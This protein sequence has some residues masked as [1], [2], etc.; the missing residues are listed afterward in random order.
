MNKPGSASNFKP[1]TPRRRRPQLGQRIFAVVAILAIL[2]GLYLIGNALIGPGKPISNLFATDTPTPTL[3]YTPTN[4]S[5]PTATPTE[6]PTPTVTFTPTPGAPFQYTVQE[7]EYLATIVD[8]FALGPE[9]I[10]LIQLLNPYDGTP[11]LG[12]DP[13]NNIVYPGQIIWIP[14]PGMALPTATPIPPDL[15]RGTRISYT[16]KA[17]D[18]LGGIAAK[19]NSTEQAIIDE[20]K[21]T[22]PNAL[23]VGQPLVIPVNMV[24]PTATRLPTSTPITPTATF[25]AVPTTKT[26]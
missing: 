1:L 23:F 21:L 5:L 20:N 26:P 14:N 2:G 16:V 10:E 12:I 25:P 15:P 19:F 22:D 8:K 6:T 13:T 11:G 4:T 9:G 7:G 17:G 3:T 24:T 18:T